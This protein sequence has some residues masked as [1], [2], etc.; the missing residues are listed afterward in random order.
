MANGTVELTPAGRD[1]HAGHDPAATKVFGF[2]VYLMSD[3]ILFATLFA[4]Y[5]VLS[6]NYAGGP[7]GKQ[8]FDLRTV[9][10][11]TAFLLTSSFTFGLAVLAR[12]ASRRDFLF[13][14]LGFT[15]AL[16]IGFLG[17]EIS[18]FAR[19]VAA[20]DG[21][22]RSAFI[23]AFFALVGTHGLHVTVGLLWMVVLAWR[24]ATGGLSAANRTRLALLGLFWHFLDV[25]WICVF[26]FV[27]LLGV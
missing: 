16:G 5:A 1:S 21:P 12:N 19:F 25:V 26:S 2:W 13:I 6:R 22:D 3:V 4:T 14:S 17:L 8:L 18:E 27:F 9:L 7:S 20:G 10:L 11:E 24:I 23:S 15:F